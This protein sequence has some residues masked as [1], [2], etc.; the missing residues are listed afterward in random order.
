MKLMKTV[1][2]KWDESGQLTSDNRQPSST[3]PPWRLGGFSQ[4]TSPNPTPFSHCGLRKHPKKFLSQKNYRE[5]PRASA[6][7]LRGVLPLGSC[8]PIR[9]NHPQSK[10]TFSPHLPS[11]IHN[12]QSTINYHQFIP[13]L[14]SLAPW[15]F[16]SS[17][18]QNSGLRKSE[19]PSPSAIQ[20]CLRPCRSR[21][22]QFS[23]FASAHTAF[24][25]QN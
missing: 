14:A 20:N 7:S 8:H 17:S 12:P 11:T 23:K 19:T 22:R 4:N 10:T 18:S 1:K 13:P 6:Q 5:N 3:S 16:H 9:T 21:L 24:I 15:R 2:E 25:I